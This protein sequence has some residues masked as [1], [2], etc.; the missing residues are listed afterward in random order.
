M[1]EAACTC[2]NQRHTLIGS[3]VT[4]PTTGIIGCGGGDCGGGSNRG[5]DDGG[6]SRGRESNGGIGF[7]RADDDGD[8]EDDVGSYCGSKRDNVTTVTGTV[9]LGLAV[10]VVA[11]ATMILFVNA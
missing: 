11:K 2:S 9:A 3:W 8:N 1:A 4:L 5:G 6:N 7:G 10:A